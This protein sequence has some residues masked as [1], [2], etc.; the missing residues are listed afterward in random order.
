MSDFDNPWKD[1][2]EHFFKH[3]LAFF[4]PEAHAAID[5]AR[6][7]ESLDKELQQ[8]V[9]E[10]ELGLRLAD[11]LF[12]VWLTDGGATWNNWKASKTRLLLW[13]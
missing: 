5:W 7:Y 10:S 6:N 1:V 2:L 3:F 11:K 4:F 9:S 13:C 12:K 8:I